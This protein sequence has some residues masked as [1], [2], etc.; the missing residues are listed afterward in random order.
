ML[1][2]KLNVNAFL[3]EA[4]DALVRGRLG[5]PRHEGLLREEELSRSNIAA[6]HQDSESRLYRI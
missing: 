4:D 6:R 5:R 1:V 2:L 3:L